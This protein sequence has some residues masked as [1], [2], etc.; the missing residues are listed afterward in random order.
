MAKGLN[1]HTPTLI[2]AI[3]TFLISHTLYYRKLS[4][5]YRRETDGQGYSGEEKDGVIARYDGRERLWTV[6]RFNLRKIKM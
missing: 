5:H 1:H 6:E 3:I 4:S 2:D